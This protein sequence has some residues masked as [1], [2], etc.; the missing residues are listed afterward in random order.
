MTHDL[1]KPE[2]LE[3]AIILIGNSDDKLSQREWSDYQHAVGESVHAYAE[4]CEFQGASAANAPWQ[5]AAWV[6]VSTAISLTLLKQSLNTIRKRFNQDSIAW[7]QGNTEFIK[8]PSSI[9]NF[10]G[11]AYPN[12]PRGTQ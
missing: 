7:I 8:E 9:V 10:G 4:D 2:R 5:N 6:I 11:M 3:T 12:G 1:V